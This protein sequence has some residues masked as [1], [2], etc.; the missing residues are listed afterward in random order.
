MSEF[1]GLAYYA[2]SPGRDL[3]HPAR[4]PVHRP[5]DAHRAGRHRSRPRCSRTATPSTSCCCPRSVEECFEMA[6]EA[7]DLAERFQ[8][9]VFV[10]SD[11]DLGMNIW[12]SDAVHVSREAARP[13]QGARRRGDSS[14]SARAGA[15]TGTS[16]ATASRTARCP[17]PAC[18]AYFTRGSGHNERGQYSERPDDYAEQPRPAARKFETARRRYVPRAGRR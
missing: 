13:R 11:L 12:M 6:M 4:R 8:T 15:A 3:R 14:G 18:R 16:T 2:E 10:M 9:P 5:A 1:A 17:A 7:F